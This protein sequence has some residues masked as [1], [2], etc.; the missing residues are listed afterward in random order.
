[1]DGEEM[2]GERRPRGTGPAGKKSEAPGAF[3]ARKTAGTGTGAGKEGA[4][5][6]RITVALAIAAPTLAELYR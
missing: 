4:P 2:K 1:M 5:D 6:N 3:R